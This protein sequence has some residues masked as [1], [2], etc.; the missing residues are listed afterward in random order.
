MNASINAS[1]NAGNKGLVN[2]GN[3]CYMNSVLQCL[4]HLLTFH[5]QNENFFDE[6]KDLNNGLM[7]EWFQFQRGMWN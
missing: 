6:C 3:T 7:Y 4:S 1:I 2:L 5:P